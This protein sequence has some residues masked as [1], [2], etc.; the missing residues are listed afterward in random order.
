MTSCVSPL[1]LGKKILDDLGIGP[2]QGFRYS[3]LRSKAVLIEA[4]TAGAQP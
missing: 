3:R 1:S 4:E 2:G